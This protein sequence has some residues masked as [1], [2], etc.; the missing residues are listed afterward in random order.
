[1]VIHDEKIIGPKRRVPKGSR[2]KGYRDVIIQDLVIEAHNTR[3]R[4]ARW[5]TPRGE[6][7]IGELPAHLADHHFGPTL[8][9]YLLYQH[10]HCQVTQPL[11][12]EQLR[13]WG[14]DIS[15]GTIDALLSA[16]HGDFHAE[17]DALL[18]TGLATASYVTVDD[19]GARHRGQNGYVTHIGNAHFAWFQ[20]TPTGIARSPEFAGSQALRGHPEGLTLSD[21]QALLR[22]VASRRSLQRR[23]DEWV[24]EGAV[25]AQG[26]RRGRRYFSAPEAERELEISPPARPSE[27]AAAPN[28]TATP[29]LVPVSAAGREIQQLVRQPLADRPPIGYRREFLERYIPNETAYLS[30]PLRHQLHELGRTPGAQ[31]PAGMYARHILN[32]LLIDLSWSSSRLEGNTYSLLD[33]Q[34]L[35]ERGTAAPGKDAKE[36]QMILNHKAAIELLVESADEVGVNRYT[37]TNLHAL[38]ADN[39]LDD[40]R[41]AGRLRTTPIAIAASTYIPTAIPQLIE[42]LFGQLLDKAAAIRDPFEQSLFL[43]VQLPYLQ[44]FVDVNKRTSRLAANIPLI[45]GNLVPLSF[46]DVPEQ[47]Y[48][49]GLICVYELNRVELLRDVYMWAYERSS[50]RYKT[51]RDSLPEPDAFRLK[52]RGALTEV[53]GT[54]VRQ[55]V[56]PTEAMVGALARPL[57]TSDDLERFVHLALEE[58]RGLHEGNIARFRIRPSEFQ[59]WQVQN[60]LGRLAT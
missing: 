40:P 18:E 56:A 48:I 36:T 27:P 57:V 20:S 28:S 8:R 1:L 60:T 23:L 7:L 24:R 49:D 10:H 55:R 52:Y 21:L 19:R 9:S 58:I 33:T 45:K 46:I 39:L 3:Y 37:V 44:P 2:F 12:H 34:E 25:R 22:G 11:L 41:N 31:R 17:K 14:I 59:Q 47:T 4:L 13:E 54:V 5:L 6:Y 51:V 42:E 53:V 32:R 50:R 30:E 15:T 43:M 35:I 38:L 29:N 16:D 26:V